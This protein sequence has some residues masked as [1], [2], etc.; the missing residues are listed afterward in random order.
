MPTID[1]SQIPHSEV[2]ALSQFVHSTSGPELRDLIDS[3][4][5]CV[6]DGATE[7]SLSAETAD[8][9]PNQAAT[10]LGM[11]RTHLYKLLDSG[12]IIF[13]RVGRDRRIRI[14]DLAK[15]EAQRQRDRRELAETFARQPQTKS[16]AI[17]EIADLL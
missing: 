4:V 1:L 2:E 11:S 17:G 15:F 5:D 16:G 14:I 6:R 8:L 9:T 7:V 12:E 3:L 13:H 10:R